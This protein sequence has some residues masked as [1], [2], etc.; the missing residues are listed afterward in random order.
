MATNSNT[1]AW[2]IP[3][4]EEPG[5]LQSM[6]LQRAGHDWGTSPSPFM[7]SCYLFL[8]SSAFFLFMDHLSWWR[9]L[10]LNEAKSHAMQGHPRWR[11]HSREFWQNMIHWRRIWQSTPVYLPWESHELYERPE[12][13]SLPNVAFEGELAPLLIPTWK[14]D[15]RNAFQAETSR[16]L[17]TF[18]LGILA[19]S[20]HPCCWTFLLQCLPQPLGP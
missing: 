18:C 1:L 12:W 2:K 9:G 20:L 5:G 15:I 14:T 17:S 4:M 7:Y 19:V 8:I 13:S 3:W 16:R 11:G 10:C 6:G